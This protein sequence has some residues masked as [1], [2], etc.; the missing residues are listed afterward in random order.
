MVETDKRRKVFALSHYNVFSILREFID[1]MNSQTQNVNIGG[2]C[3]LLAVI[4]EHWA[5]LGISGLRNDMTAVF[6]LM[7]CLLKFKR[8]NKTR[9]N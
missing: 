3:D 4:A 8:E 2:N 1:N 5:V 9:G 7:K 6:Q